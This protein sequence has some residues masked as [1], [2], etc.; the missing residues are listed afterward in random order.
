VS[1]ASALTEIKRL[2]GL[3][4]IVYSSHA[5]DR[6]FER[7]ATARDVRAALLSATVARWQADR[8]NFKVDG[9]VDCDGD[10]MTVIV[11]IQADVI[12]VTIF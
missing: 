1:D 6:M 7:G 8:R 5:R 10:E 9:G 11:D 2:A 3:N 4:R 12:V